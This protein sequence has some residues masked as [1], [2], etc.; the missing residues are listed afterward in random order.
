VGIAVDGNNRVYVADTW[1]QRV[2]VFE[3]SIGSVQ[4][5]PVLEWEIDGWTSD[6]L[7]NKPFLTAS[8]TGQVFVCDPEGYRI[9]EFNPDGQFV[10]TWGEFSNEA[11]GFGL[12]TAAALDGRGGIYIT[13]AGNNR[14]LH[15]E[16]P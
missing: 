5:F 9:L 6:S 12:A 16:L 8:R 13:D 15:F 14:I 4:Y 3:K 11:D 7:D 1:N 10:R 2:Q